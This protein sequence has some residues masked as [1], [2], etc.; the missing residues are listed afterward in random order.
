MVDIFVSSVVGIIVMVVWL[1]LA[2]IATIYEGTTG[3]ALPCGFGILLVVGFDTGYFTILYWIAYWFAVAAGCEKWPESVPPAWRRPLPAWLLG[4][5]A[6][7]R[8][9][10]PGCPF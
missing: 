4:G 9:R 10:L 7:L 2:Y 1:I 5:L 3:A 6:W 8:A